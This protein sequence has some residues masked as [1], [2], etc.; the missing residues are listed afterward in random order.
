MTAVQAGGKLGMQNE[1]TVL[2]EAVSLLS[3]WT[4]DRQWI[5]S[6]GY[7]PTTL[8]GACD[9]QPTMIRERLDAAWRSLGEALAILTDY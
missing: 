1:L 3:T 7:K 5:I 6:A 9:P 8:I 4:E 2:R